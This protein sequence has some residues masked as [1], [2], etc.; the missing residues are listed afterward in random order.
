VC[1]GPRVPPDPQRLRKV[2]SPAQYLAICEHL[3]ARWQP[4]TDL[5]LD[6]ACRWGELAELRV[7]DLDRDHCELRVVRTV[8]EIDVAH[9]PPECG[10]FLIKDY[11]KNPHD[12]IVALG[13][14]LG[15]RLITTIVQS[16]SCC[17]PP[18]TR[19]GHEAGWMIRRCL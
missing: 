1:R 3:P 2:I 8:V 16:P 18:A 10:R 11:P 14:D 17:F 9:R 13:A 4:L 5:A 19:A 12:R 7:K 6:S 15:A